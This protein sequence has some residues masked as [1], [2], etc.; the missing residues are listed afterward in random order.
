MWSKVKCLLFVAV[1]IED[2]YFPSGFF[3]GTQID[4]ISIFS[5]LDDQL[6]P[7]LNV[8]SDIQAT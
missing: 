5:N 4:T 8:S 3:D 6:C 2:V 7:L 1:L